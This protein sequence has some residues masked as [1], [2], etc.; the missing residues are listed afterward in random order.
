MLQLE[1][2][3][4]NEFEFQVDITGDDSKTAPIV[5]FK[6]VAPNVTLAYPTKKVNG[7]YEVAID[8]LTGVLEPG[9]YTCEICVYLGDRFFVPMHESLELKPKIVPVVSHFTMNKVEAETPQIR[10]EAVTKKE[11]P[12][13]ETVEVVRKKIQ[14]KKK[15]VVTK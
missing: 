1:I 4:R 11:P 15:A 6:I 12:I 10:V 14:L 2:D 5:E 3:K 13:T 9:K 8:P 7:L